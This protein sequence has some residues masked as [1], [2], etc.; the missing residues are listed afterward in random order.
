[1]C[2][3]I[4]KD[5]SRKKLNQ[6]RTLVFRICCRK[7]IQTTETHKNLGTIFKLRATLE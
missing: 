2:T 1:M 5:V 7:D 6:V 4:G 3:G